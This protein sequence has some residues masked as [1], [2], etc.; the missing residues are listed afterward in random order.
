[1]GRW[2]VAHSKIMRKREWLI[3]NG[4]ETILSYAKTEQMHHVLW[5]Y[6]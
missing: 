1:L 6:F 5:D 2:E 4:F 3:A